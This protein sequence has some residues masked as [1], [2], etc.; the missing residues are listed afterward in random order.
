MTKTAHI[1]APARTRSSSFATRRLGD[2]EEQREKRTPGGDRSPTPRRGRASRR[3]RPARRR[4]STAVIGQEA[5]EEAPFPGAAQR[6]DQE[7]T[8]RRQE[9]S[10]SNPPEF[11]FAT[12]PAGS[13]CS[14][15][16][17]PL[18]VGERPARHVRRFSRGAISEARCRRRC[19]ALPPGSHLPHV[20]QPPRSSSQS[21]SAIVL[22][23]ERRS[24][25][26]PS[27]TK[28]SR[29]GSAAVVVRIRWLRWWMWWK[30]MLPV[31]Q[32]Q[33]SRH[34]VVGAAR[35]AAVA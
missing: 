27:G 8:E 30:P 25:R 18:P 20:D 28:G 14:Q 24:G 6:H 31:N 22:R 19:G 1:E 5:A 2:L 32:L 29:R 10:R 11:D 12:A 17:T 35:S 23:L 4:G 3:Q 15:V 9:S 33:E 16:D 7:E 34:L 26:S 21:L 13:G